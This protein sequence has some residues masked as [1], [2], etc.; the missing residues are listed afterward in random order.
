[1]FIVELGTVRNALKPSDLDLCKATKR[2][3]NAKLKIEK[4]SNS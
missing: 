1:M 4:H 2:V 3:C